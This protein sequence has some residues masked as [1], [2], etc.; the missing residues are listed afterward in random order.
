MSVCTRACML[1]QP[2]GATSSRSKLCLASGWALARVRH[3][4]AGVRCSW[5]GSGW[6]VPPLLPGAQKNLRDSDTPTNSQLLRPFG[7]HSAQKL[8]S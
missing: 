8:L 3:M 5:D 4:P 7:A 1:A 2:S 6:E